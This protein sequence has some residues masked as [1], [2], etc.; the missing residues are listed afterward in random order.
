MSET[1]VNVDLA[2]HSHQVQQCRVLI[3]L[4]ESIK[5]EKQ[6]MFLNNNKLVVYILLDAMVDGWLG[7]SNLPWMVVLQQMQNTLIL[8]Q[9]E[10]VVVKQE[11]ILLQV[12]I[13][14]KQVVMMLEIY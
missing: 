12:I 5:V 10:D 2:G 11:N 4:L 3:W 13:I 14:N 7:V 1:K 8:H 9:M 6:Y